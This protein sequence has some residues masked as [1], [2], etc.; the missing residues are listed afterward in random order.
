MNKDNINSTNFIQ[1]V[2]ENY[3]NKEPINI[4]KEYD[5]DKVHF[6]E[7]SDGTVLSSTSTD[8]NEY[9]NIDER[10]YNL[11]ILKDN[12]NMNTN[13]D[14]NNYRLTRTLNEYISKM[15]W[16]NKIL[17]YLWIIVLYK[18]IPVKQNGHMII[19]EPFFQ[20]LKGN[21]HSTYWH[22]NYLNP[23][24][25]IVITLFVMFMFVMNCILSVIEIFKMTRVIQIDIDD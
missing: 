5:K 1:I 13:N 15:S 20:T 25:Y 9:D 21:T 12:D 6:I 7:Y 11:S 3:Y 23:L 8:I 16:F 10:F 2:D 17:Y 19:E 14:N 22:W 4:V 18:K 24:T